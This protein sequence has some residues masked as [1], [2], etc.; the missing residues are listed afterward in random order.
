LQTRDLYSDLKSGPYYYTWGV[1]WRGYAAYIAGILINVVGFA[2]AVG[3][4]VPVGATYIYNLNYFCGFIVSSGVYYLV[5]R[6]WPVPACSD[7]WLEID[8]DEVMR[9]GSLAYGGDRPSDDDGDYGGDKRSDV[10]K[11]V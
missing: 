4:S 11:G 3:A 8:D 2:G 9:G 5:C 1:S 6:V 7:T 10:P